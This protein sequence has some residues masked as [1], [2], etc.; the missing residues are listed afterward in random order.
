MAG[1]LG[2]EPVTLYG[3]ARKKGR[4]QKQIGLL[5]GLGWKNPKNYHIFSPNTKIDG[6]EAQSYPDRFRDTLS[7]FHT[8]YHIS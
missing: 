7:H 3:L 4:I 5:G 6:M 1:S 8:V 2:C